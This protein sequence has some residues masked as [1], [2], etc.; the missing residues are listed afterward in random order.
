MCRPLRKCFIYQPIKRS[1]SQ[2]GVL[3]CVVLGGTCV[4]D[5]RLLSNVEAKAAY[6]KFHQLIQSI[7]GSINRWIESWSIDCWTGPSID[8]SIDP[9][10][11]PSLPSLHQSIDQSSDRSID[12]GNKFSEH[13]DTFFFRVQ[14]SKQRNK[15]AAVAF[16]RFKLKVSNL[17]KTRADIKVGEFW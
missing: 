13:T 16:S 5:E 15:E 4:K 11:R 10:I 3:L 6:Q 1:I 2:S 14:Q 7:D 12:L 17:V 9:S 8:Q